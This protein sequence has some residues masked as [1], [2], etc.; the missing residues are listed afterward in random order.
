MARTSCLTPIIATVAGGV[1]MS[2]ACIGL[3]LSQQPFVS[4]TSASIVMTSYSVS[5]YIAAWCIARWVCLYVWRTT[6]PQ[7]FHTQIARRPRSLHCFPLLVA[8]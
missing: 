2:S 4:T 3:S 6:S 1:L 7:A 8:A 5:V